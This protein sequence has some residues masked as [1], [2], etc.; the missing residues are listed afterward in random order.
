MPT[1]RAAEIHGWFSGTSL[2]L[3]AVYSGYGE[4]GVAARGNHDA[5]MTVVNRFGARCAQPRRQQTVLRG[6][7]ST[8]LHIAKDGD[9]RFQA[10]QFFEFS[11]QPQCVA[12]MVLIQL[13]QL[14]PGAR[15]PRRASRLRFARLGGSKP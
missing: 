5:K 9:T 2:R 1:A 6:R 12:S 7:R 13:C 3:P 14:G 11:G 10:G 4:G 15:H 8:P